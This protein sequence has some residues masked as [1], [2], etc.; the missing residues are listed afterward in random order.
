VRRDEIDADLV[1]RLVAGQFAQW[2]H[3]P[4]RAV[5]DSGWDNR[6]F[7][8]G[9]SMLVRLPSAASYEAQVEKEHRWLPW[10]APHLP[11]PI[12]VPLAMG[13]PAEGYPWRWSVYRW[14]PG[15]TARR[16]RI[17]DLGQFA[18][19]VA[20]FLGALYEI[21]ASEGP[22]AGAHSFQ[23]GGPVTVWDGQVRDALVTLEGRVD[24]DTA[25]AAWEAALAATVERSPVWVP[26]VWVHGDVARG[27]L[28]VRDGRLSAVIDFG[29]SAVGDP[30][31]D[32]AVAWT[33]LDRPGREALRTALPLDDATWMRGHG[34]ALWKALIVLAR[35]GGPLTEDD[36]DAPRVLDELLADF[37]AG[38]VG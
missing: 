38:W 6:T 24:T 16:E 21:D 22:P 5:A 17:A 13:E 35:E 10:L 28:L 20:A 31:C 30:A 8:L 4:V 9:D 34:W 15:E 27:N 37:R 32:L 29:C 1:R 18:R 19:D 26:P 36:H 11:L 14:I 23:R 2:A 25:R 33:L 7:H 12:P 3:L